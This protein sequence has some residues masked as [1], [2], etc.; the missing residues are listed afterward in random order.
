LTLQ[1]IRVTG[2]EGIGRTGRRE[3]LLAGDEALRAAVE[4]LDHSVQ[5]GQ[6]DQREHGPPGTRGV[7]EVGIRGAG[8]SSSSAWTAVIM[9]LPSTKALRHE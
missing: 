7:T 4:L 6:S 2:R 8:R 5:F 9:P 3:E 1:V